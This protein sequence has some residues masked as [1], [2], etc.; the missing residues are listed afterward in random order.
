MC[1]LSQEP[2]ERLQHIKACSRC[3]FLLIHNRLVSIPK[4]VKICFPRHGRSKAADKTAASCEGGSHG[5]DNLAPG[6]QSIFVAHGPA[7]KQNVT[8]R[9]FRNIELYEL[10]AGTCS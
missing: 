10:M 3:F 2:E 5:Y 9:P 1:S 8:A 4:A 7:F 6:M